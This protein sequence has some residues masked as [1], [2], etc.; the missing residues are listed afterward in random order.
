MGFTFLNDP[1]K[2]RTDQVFTLVLMWK[3]D[4]RMRKCMYVHIVKKIAEYIKV[5]LSGRFKLTDGGST[6]FCHV[7]FRDKL[8][9]YYE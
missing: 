6:Y 8:S 4:Q 2:L 9:N 5:D 3:Q 1:W 7:T